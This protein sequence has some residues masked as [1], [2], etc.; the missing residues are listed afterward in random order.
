[1]YIREQILR[2]F[3]GI[4]QVYPLLSVTNIFH[5]YCCMKNAR[6]AFVFAYI[7][8]LLMQLA[9]TVLFTHK[10]MRHVDFPN[11]RTTRSVSNIRPIYIAVAF[12][13]TTPLH[14]NN[15]LAIYV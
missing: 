8:A 1:M 3:D 9:C 6:K 13:F 15:A 7:I 5:Y 4:I 2:F 14:N 10:S 12:A 11:A